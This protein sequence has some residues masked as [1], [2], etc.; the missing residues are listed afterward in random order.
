MRELFNCREEQMHVNR[1]TPGTPIW[2]NEAID[3]YIESDEQPDGRGWVL[4]DD[5]LTFDSICKHWSIKDAKAAMEWVESYEDKIK[6]KQFKIKTNHIINTKRVLLREIN[7]AIYDGFPDSKIS[8]ILFCA[9]TS[10]DWKT[11]SN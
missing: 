8:E 3:C 1:P 5:G 9:D 2:Y 11:L 7:N 6:Q 4:H 10:L